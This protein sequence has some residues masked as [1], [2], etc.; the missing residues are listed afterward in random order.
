MGL[1]GLSNLSYFINK[2]NVIARSIYSK[3]LHPIH[4]YP[5]A[6]VG[7]NITSWIYNLLTDGFLKTHFY[8]NSEL[9]SIEKFDLEDIHKIYCNF[10]L[11]ITLNFY[12]F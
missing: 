7:I 2:Q 3:S 4:G 1:L 6:I 9:L 11:L 12:C 5:F 8:N 10:T